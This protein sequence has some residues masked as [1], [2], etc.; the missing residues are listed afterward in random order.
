L[1][2][3]LEGEALAL[4]EAIHLVVRHGW[5]RVIFESD[6]HILVHSVVTNNHGNSEFSIIVASIFFTRK[7]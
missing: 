1:L 7:G 2:T 4:L 6:S 5:D 3:V